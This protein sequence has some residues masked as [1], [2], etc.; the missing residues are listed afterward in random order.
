MCDNKIEV[1]ITMQHL[2]V[3]WTSLPDISEVTKAT[4]EYLS[5]NH[6]IRIEKHNVAGTLNV[7]VII[8][9]DPTEYIYFEYTV[10]FNSPDVI[11]EMTAM[12]SHIA[13]KYLALRA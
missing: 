4:L 3:D 9:D 2:L 13:G 5:D 6:L 7:D 1:W 10:W 11:K 8:V 12:L